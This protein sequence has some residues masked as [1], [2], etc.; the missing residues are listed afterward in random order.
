MKRI[1]I[2]LIVTTASLSI[3]SAQEDVNPVFYRYFLNVA[4]PAF[5]G[6]TGHTNFGANV[7]S[8]NANVKGA[9]ELQIFVFDTPLFSNVGFGVSVSNGK[10]FI[11]KQTTVSFDFSYK[12]VLNRNGQNLYFGLKTGFSSY[13]A[14]TEGLTTFGIVEDPLLQNINTGLNPNFG[15]GFQFEDPSNFYVAFS[16]PRI[17][18]Y[19]RLFERNKTAKLSPDRIPFYLSGGAMM[20]LGG[21]I[22]FKPTLLL[23]YMTVSPFFADISALFGFGEHLDFGASYR[24]KESIS[25]L[26]VFR[27]TDSFRVGYAYGISL[28]GELRKVSKGSHEVFLNFRL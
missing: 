17:L 1:I 28:M 6:S 4:N 24:Y 5:A 21:G 25:G 26:F 8:Q 11:E 15:I 20:D 2:T 23:Q 27:S 16:I 9:P 19:E 14:N 12:L 10:T 13:S 7:R 18:S 3:L 22:T